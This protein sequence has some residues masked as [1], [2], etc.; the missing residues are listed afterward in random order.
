MATVTVTTTAT[1]SPTA[2]SPPASPAPTV[3]V[4][5]TAA[6]SGAPAEENTLYGDP[7]KCASDPTSLAACAFTAAVRSDKTATLTENARA[8]AEAL[9]VPGGPWGLQRCELVGDV[10]AQCAVLF[11]KDPTTRLFLT[12]MPTTDGK[13]YEVIHAQMEFR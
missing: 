6:A 11:L 4:T 9:V 7:P 13:A 12:L 10:T 8:A 3:T 1:P 2:G 5:A